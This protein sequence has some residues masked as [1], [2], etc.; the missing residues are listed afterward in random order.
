MKRAFW[1]A[2]ASLFAASAGQAQQVNQSESAW[3]TDA[4]AEIERK[5]ARQPITGRAGASCN[6]SLLRHQLRGDAPHLQ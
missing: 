6:P 2:T 5:L 1:L 4:Q 3:Y